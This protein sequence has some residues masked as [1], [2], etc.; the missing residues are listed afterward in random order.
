M[1]AGMAIMGFGGGAV[2]G[3]PLMQHLVR[4]F[5]EPPQYLGSKEEVPLV[6]EGGRRYAT[7]GN[8]KK[9]VVVVAANERNQMIVPGP[10]GVYAVGTGNA[11]VAQ[12]FFVLGLG[13]MVVMLIAAFSYRIPAPGW[14]PAGWT[15]PTEGETQRKM[16]STHAVGINEALRTHQ[17]Y[18]L[19]V[20]LCLN[21]TA[22]IGILA[23]GRDMMLDIFGTSLPDIVTAGFAT[24]FVLMMSVFNMAGRFGWASASDYLGRQRTY[25]IFFALG[26]LL[27]LAIPFIAK[28]S[29]LLPPVAWLVL[30]YAVVMAIMTMYGGG[31]ATIPA[32]LADLFGSKFVGGIHGRLL[33]AWSTAGVLGPLAITGLR[34]S[35]RREAIE[36][37]AGK[38]DPE[39]FREQFGT[40]VE[41]LPQLIEQKTVTIKKLLAIAPQGTPDPTVHLYS[42]TMYLMVALLAVAFVANWL[43][44]P[45]KPEHYL[46]EREEKKA[47]GAA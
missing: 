40:G 47:G 38:V 22:G 1:A 30:F 24:T 5:Y 6:T 3:S 37:L 2:I 14:V 39:R 32:Y 28:Q 43:V 45:V 36:D 17:F 4:T 9:E 25:L 13:Y 12:T 16:V 20:V 8:E 33:T 44:K 41:Q 11:G 35:A 46:N 10:A 42:S 21:V 34:E 29:P 26:M 31:F 27:Y 7:V 19:W 18:L 15:P 23:V